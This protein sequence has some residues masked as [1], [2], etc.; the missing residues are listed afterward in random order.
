MFADGRKET[1][2][3]NGL[4]FNRSLKRRPKSFGRIT[5]A[6][7]LFVSANQGGLEKNS[8]LPD[9]CAYCTNGKGANSAIEPSFT[10]M[11]SYLTSLSAKGS[12]CSFLF[13]KSVQRPGKDA[14]SQLWICDPPVLKTIVAVFWSDLDS[15]TFLGPEG[16][17]FLDFSSAFFIIRNYKKILHHNHAKWV[18]RAFHF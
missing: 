12:S 13:C 7:N 11:R 18:W 6:I 9:C 1:S 2:A 4:W 10:E 17:F 14:K 15:L 5:R 3:I 16:F 8:H